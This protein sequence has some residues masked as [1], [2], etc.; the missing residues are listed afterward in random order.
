MYLGENNGNLS[1]TKNVF[2]SQPFLEMRKFL[3]NMRKDF[4]IISSFYLVEIRSE[5]N[6]L[7]ILTSKKILKMNNYVLIRVFFSNNKNQEFAE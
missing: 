2:C 3:L 1:K 6:S 4:V 5:P 7:N